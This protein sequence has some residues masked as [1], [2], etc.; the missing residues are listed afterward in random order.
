A[1]IERGFYQQLIAEEAYRAQQRVASGEDVIV[2]VNAYR[3][4]QAPAP[5]RFDVPPSLEAA[6]LERLAELR[7]SRDG[8]A[9]SSSLVRLGEA[10]AGNGDLMGPI[11]GSVEA[12]ATLGEI[13]GSLRE[14]F[15]EYRPDAAAVI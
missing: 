15:G 1:A 3:D 13:C 14:V 2:G 4:E 11:V 5:E 6:Q 10:A 7:A 12:G 9:V 8:H